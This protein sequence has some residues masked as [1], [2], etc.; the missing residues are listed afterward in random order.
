LGFGTAKAVIASR[1]VT[2]HAS[3]LRSHL[4]VKLA[5]DGLL[6]RLIGCDKLHEET[7]P[8]VKKQLL[9]LA[10]ELGPAQW[11]LDL[12]GVR[13]LSSTGLGM[14]LVLS[15]KVQGFGGH[16]TLCGVNAMVYE[17][18]EVT[19]LTRVLDVRRE[20]L[21]PGAGERR[22]PPHPPSDRSF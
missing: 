17:L 5:E 14:L 18:F 4:Q 10:Q 13:F 20:H 12:G 21:I 19:Q 6:V 15:K 1:A 22:A 2:V 16:L 7:I 9:G 11:H 8:A 3:T